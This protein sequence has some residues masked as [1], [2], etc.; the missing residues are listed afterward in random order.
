MERYLGPQGLAPALLA[1]LIRLRTPVVATMRAQQYQAF[2]PKP[3]EAVTQGDPASPQAA[4]IGAR[5]LNLIEPVHLSRTWSGDELARA[6][7]CTDAR[8]VDALAHHGHSG[9]AEYLAA[10]PAL[11]QEWRAASQVGGHPRG[12]ALVAAAVDL[13][14]SGL[15]GPYSL[16]LLTQAHEH[17][18]A[19]AGGPLLRPEPV[20]RALAWATGARY[21]ITSLLS[22]V[23]D[24]LWIPFD[25]LVDRTHSPVP[26]QVRVL[27]LAHARDDADRFNIALFAGVAA[28]QLSEAVWRPQA[29]AGDT[30]AM[31]NLGT[32]LAAAGR[33]DEAEEL[34]RRA[35]DAGDMVAAD[36]LGLLL[37]RADRLQEAKEV[38]RRGAEAGNGDAAYRLVGLLYEEGL[39]DEAQRVCRRAAAAGH[40]NSAFL[41]AAILRD[42]GQTQEAIRMYRRAADAGH[43][44]GAFT[45][46]LLQFNAGQTGEAEE[47]FRRA[48]KAGHLDANYNLAGLLIETD[49][50]EEAKEVCR[51]GAEA[52]D[53]DAAY[54]LAGLLCDQEFTD[55]VIAQVQAI[56]RPAAEAGHADCANLLA[57]FLQD[58]GQL[59]EASRLYQSA[60]DAGHAGATHNLANLLYEAMRMD[61]AEEK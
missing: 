52:G 18:L 12:A 33:L 13:A 14:R 38:C 24:N 8:I 53:G 9:I 5:V 42:S 3:H 29:E 49:R 37:I 1:E 45:L 19:A 44:E 39:I 58:A 31:V 32:V 22:P 34:Y 2:A 57:A 40:A 16:D 41:L 23:S 36:N 28:P 55:E 11:W 43:V 56:C 10:G 46:G 21:G 61:D 27:A 54:R 50:R 7:D 48:A 30:L 17:Y 47:M 20:D 51:R 26:A 59:E 35:L 15:A 4:S 60:A 25:Y 6:Q